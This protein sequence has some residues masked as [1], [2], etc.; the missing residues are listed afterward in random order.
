MLTLLSTALSV[1]YSLF[2]IKRII[3]KSTA[4][5]IIFY[6]AKNLLR[7]NLKNTEIPDSALNE[8]INNSNN[9]I[10][11]F[12]EKTEKIK[13]NKKPTNE[14]NNL[15]VDL[16]FILQN[17]KLESELNSPAG[18]FND[19]QNNLSMDKL[20]N[21][22]MYKYKINLE[23]FSFPFIKQSK[24]HELDCN[25]DIKSDQ[26]IVNVKYAKQKT[27]MINEL[28]IKINCMFL[29]LCN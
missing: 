9:K 16:A 29:F 6:D 8:K 17:F 2:I 13:N 15:T 3:S 21:L 26:K 27:E 18:S 22:N 11:K 7:K 5:Q 12:N 1:F 20:N 25:F 4:E 10:N 23:H 19:N 24:Y 28:D 14:T